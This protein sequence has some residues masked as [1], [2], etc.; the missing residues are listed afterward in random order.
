MS[1]LYASVTQGPD[2]EDYDDYLAMTGRYNVGVG[3]SMLDLYLDALPE[4]FKGIAVE[5][6][7]VLCSEMGGVF[8]DKE[9][10]ALIDCIR[11]F[12]KCKSTA[13]R[14]ALASHIKVQLLLYI[15]FMRGLRQKHDGLKRGMSNV[16]REAFVKRADEQELTKEERSA[17]AAHLQV[18]GYSQKRLENM[19]DGYI[20]NARKTMWI[21]KPRWL[22]KK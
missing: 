13:R 7:R 1:S 9:L 10:K 14:T 18:G 3:A 15:V 4:F 2:P 19:M 8:P 21:E 22:K 17:V 5:R 11:E 12:N 16:V 20:A 6:D